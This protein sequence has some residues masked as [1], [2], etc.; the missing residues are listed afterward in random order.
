M[1]EPNKNETR[2]PTPTE[3]IRNHDRAVA[4]RTAKSMSAAEKPTGFVVAKGKSLSTPRGIISGDDA[5]NI[6]GPDDF[7]TPAAFKQRQDE[8]YVVAVEDKAKK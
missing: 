1:A 4:E 5:N 2:E 7:E 3:V 8:G 6:I